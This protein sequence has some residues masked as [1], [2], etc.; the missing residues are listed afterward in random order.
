MAQQDVEQQCITGKQ[1]STGCK[2]ALE[3]LMEFNS[4]LLSPVHIFFSQ[5]LA[6]LSSSLQPII[7]TAIKLQEAATASDLKT[8][9]LYTITQIPGAPPI[10]YEHGS[11]V[12]P[13]PPS[14]FKILASACSPE[15]SPEPGAQSSEE[16]AGLWTAQVGSGSLNP[17]APPRATHQQAGGNWSDSLDSCSHPSPCANLKETA[18][19]P[20]PEHGHLG[21][22]ACSE[23]RAQGW[24]TTRSE[25]VIQ[26]H[27][28]TQTSGRYSGYQYTEGV[29]KS[30][31][32]RTRGAPD[33]GSWLF[34]RVLMEAL[35]H[36][37]RNSSRTDDQLMPG[38]D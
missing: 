26:L 24:E 1:R 14:S 34:W 18:H 16:P 5:R 38:T 11:Q 2:G 28:S 35:G 8:S 37:V 30:F 19:L 13:P 36:G 31:G 9:K 15:S 33:P 6:P 17:G 21:S 29:I 25:Y 23:L 3:E 12:I 7:Q 22:Q 10:P 27:G 4:R 32:V 20:H